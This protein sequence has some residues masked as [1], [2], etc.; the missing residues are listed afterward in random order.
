MDVLLELSL[1]FH[2]EQNLVAKRAAA[3]LQADLP[4]S[5]EKIQV[6]QRLVGLTEVT[7]G[8]KKK[9]LPVL[10]D[11]LVLCITNVHT[12]QGAKKTT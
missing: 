10:S 4:G 7:V 11:R 1:E 5:G 6:G 12:D 2:L 3:R 9:T 8:G